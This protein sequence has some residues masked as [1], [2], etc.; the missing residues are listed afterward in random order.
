VGL[1]STTVKVR[2]WLEEQLNVTSFPW[3]TFVEEQGG[4]ERRP[5]PITTGYRL[6]LGLFL[7]RIECRRYS[8]AMNLKRFALPA[9]P[10]VGLVVTAGWYAGLIAGSWLFVPAYLLAIAAPM[11][12]SF[13]RRVRVFLPGALLGHALGWFL[14]VRFC[15]SSNDDGLGIAFGTMFLLGLA[16]LNLTAATVA[17]AVGTAATH[18]LGGGPPPAPRGTGSSAT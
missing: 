6:T 15:S 9:W 2:P 17:G 3:V 7:S 16:V 10:L 4:G 13:Q 14:W 1:V 11:A 12:A 8:C 5:M 18:L